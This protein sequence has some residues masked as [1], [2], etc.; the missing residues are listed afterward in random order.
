MGF[1][2]KMFKIETETATCLFYKGNKLLKFSA[3]PTTM[4]FFLVF[5]GGVFA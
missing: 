5:F 1:K 4:G 3:F 2:K